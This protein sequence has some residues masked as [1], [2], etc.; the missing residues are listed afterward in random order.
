MND[1][2]V[3]KQIKQMVDFI[4][5][6]AKEKANEILI[7][8]TEEF[9]IEKLRLVNQEVRECRAELCVCALRGAADVFA[10]RP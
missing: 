3:D 6:E 8:A 9:N 2:D 7:K 5:Q 1:K 10:C 4:T